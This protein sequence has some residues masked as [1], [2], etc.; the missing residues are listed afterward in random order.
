MRRVRDFRF[1]P[2]EGYELGYGPV[3]PPAMS[4]FFYVVGS[5]VVDTAQP[6]MGRQVLD[7]LGERAL[8]HVLLTHH[9]EDHS[10]N[11]GALARQFGIPALGHPLTAEKLRA[12]F[13]VRPYQH[14]VWGRP[15]R[16]EVTAYPDRI[17]VGD[18][19]FLPIHTPGH[20][21]DH[22]VYLEEQHGWL[23]SGDLYL[24]DR[25]KFF[26]SD[27][28]LGDQIASLE[29]VLTFDFDALLCSHRPRPK[30][31]RAHLERKLDFLGSLHATV[32]E[33][34]RQG[35]PERAIIRRLKPR[36]DWKIWWMT[37]GNV[38]FAHLVRSSVR[39]AR[40]ESAGAMPPP[41][42]A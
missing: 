23:F 12:G 25:I 39:L 14:Y 35:L 42:P 7:I 13:R 27:E 2:V 19:R 30:G 34:T 26:R 36:G 41:Q 18:L 28:R 40:G 3:G 5:V 24:G 9:H 20:S 6:H 31:G 16:A 29:K 38:G 8:S 32:S 17:E 33:W 11:A 10:G 1:G 37:L 15:T 22:T 21:K 4:V